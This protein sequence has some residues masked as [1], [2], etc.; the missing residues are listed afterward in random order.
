MTLSPTRSRCGARMYD[1]SPSWYFTRAMNALRFGSYS[2]RSTVAGTSNFRR[3]K[4]IVR[5][6]CLCPP[7][8]NRLVIRPWLLRPPELLCPSVR[9]LTGLPFHNSLLSIRTVPRRLAVTGLYCLS[10]ISRALCEAGG[11]ID[12]LA[13]GQLHEGFLDVRALARP[14]LEPLGLAL[15]HQG[16]H[17]QHLDAEQPLHRGLDLGLGGI[18]RDAE[19][20]LVL[21]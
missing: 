18:D 12:R 16:V 19:H 8:R 2:S 14:S 4:S 15:L 1:S 13:R 9:P 3:L 20:H 10:A 11:E 7:P 6:A 5:Y 17:C 21:L